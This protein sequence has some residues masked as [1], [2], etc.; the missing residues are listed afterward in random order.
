MR[1][2]VAAPGERRFTI[3]SFYPPGWHARAPW[4]AVPFLPLAGRWMSDL[5]FEIGT[6]VVVTAE[7][8]EVVVRL[9]PRGGE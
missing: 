5:R 4:E 3:A 8:G 2:S 7:Y 1:E 6:D 9:R